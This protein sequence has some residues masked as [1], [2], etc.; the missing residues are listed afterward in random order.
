MIKLGKSVSLN[1]RGD[2]LWSSKVA[3]VKVT[4][5][6]LA[7]LDEEHK[8]GELR[9]VFDTKTWNVNRDGLIYTDSQFEREL[10]KFLK[11]VDLKPASVSYSEQGLQGDNYVSLDV[12]KSFIKSWMK[13]FT[14]TV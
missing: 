4:A 9:V 14:V 6:H 1:T 8:F 12:G 5:L 7:Y 13:K 11:T 2:G 3:A 10:K